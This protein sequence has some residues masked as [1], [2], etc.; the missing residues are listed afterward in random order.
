MTAY[1]KHFSQYAVL[2]YDK[3]FADVSPSFWAHVVQ[4]M[5]A[6][7]I[8]TGVSDTLF[9]PE[10]NVTRAEFAAMIHER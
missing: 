6:K 7:H 8:V 5:A 3:S 10:G 2:E 9:N 1:V 4:Q